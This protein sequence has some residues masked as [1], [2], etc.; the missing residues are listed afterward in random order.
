MI[1]PIE[2]LINFTGN[3]YEITCAATRR[4]YQISM[5]RDEDNKDDES[6]DK[7]VSIAAKQIFTKEVQYRIEHNPQ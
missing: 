1:F 2:E 6:T 5:L 4:A 7:A 3:I